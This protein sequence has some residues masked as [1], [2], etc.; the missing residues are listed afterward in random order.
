M[1]VLK[2]KKVSGRLYGR[3]IVHLYLGQFDYEPSDPT[4]P[5]TKDAERIKDPEMAAL[6][7][8]LCLYLL[9]RGVNTLDGH[10]FILSEAHTKKDID[11]TV[12]AFGLA[13]DDMIAEGGVPKAE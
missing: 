1:Q 3:T 13:L 11:Q 2:K 12:E 9:H 10:Y 6:K 7:I 8:R 5:P 4:V